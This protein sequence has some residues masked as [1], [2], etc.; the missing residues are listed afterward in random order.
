MFKKRSIIILLSLAAIL[1]ITACNAVLIGSG[2]V[3]TETVQ[4][5]NFDRI[6]LEGLG[7]VRVTQDGSEAL[8]VETYDNVMELII[9]EVEGGTL[10]L[11]LKDANKMLLPRK[12]VFHVSVDDLTGLAVAGSGGIEAETIS[13]EQLDA[14][15]GGSGMI[16]IADLT[17]S[18]VKAKIS[19]S[20]QI[21]LAGEA[22]EQDISIS[23]SGKYKAGDVCSA[24]VKV[25]ISGSGGATVCATETLD[26]KI[27]GSGSV[28]YYGRPAINSSGSGSGSINSL[29]EK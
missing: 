24:S 22:A 25:S 13:T 29:G 16:Q 19:G 15:I 23:G 18:E 5:S 6:S 7:E 2:G 11:G 17:T 21:D 1:T 27:S 9:A 3:I 10:K 8:M 4:V 12:L 20:G 28:D 26:T 14:A